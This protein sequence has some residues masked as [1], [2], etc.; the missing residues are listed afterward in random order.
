MASLAIDQGIFREFSIR[1]K[2]EKELD[3]RRVEQI[4]RA[5]ATWFRQRE[6][7]KIV[8]GYDARLSSPGLHQALSKGLLESG[9]DVVDIGF[10]PTPVHNFATDFYA[11]DGGVMVTASHNPPEY[12]GLKIRAV[13]TLFG[14][15][16]QEIYRIAVS[17]KFTSGTGMYRSENVL[18]AYLEAVTKDIQLPRSLK[19]VFDAGNGT[20]GPV[21]PALLRSLGC[22]VIELYCQPDGNFPHRSPDPTAPGATRDLEQ[23]VVKQGADLGLAFDGDGDR[24]ILVDEKGNT[25][26]GDTALMLLARYLLQQQGPIKVVYEVLC[27]QAVPDDIDAHGGQAI[28]AP[29][30]YALVHNTMLDAGAVLGGELSGHFFLLN[31]IF[32]FD[33]AILATTRL[34]AML[35]GQSQPLSALADDL[36]HYF[37]SREY[38]LA[39]PDELKGSLV[40]EMDKAFSGSHTIERIDGV[41]VLFEDGWALI[42]QSNT[43]PVISLRFE[44]KT[45]LHNMQAIRDQV[46]AQL[47][48]KYLNHNLAWDDQAVKD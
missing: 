44:A 45:S 37:T 31:D 23:E 21:V 32:R 48:Q 11:A 28:P 27:T 15:D 40:A 6:G 24:V 41:R 36:P 7:K 12:N 29:S 46:M 10:V 20:T 43:Q 42:R 47:K 5:I 39:C 16:L 3:E 34:L 38:R 8:I 9:I 33:D 19:L 26:M 2:V 25:L 18:P 4:G 13:H 35:A 30:G 1:G 22:Q 17:G 14:D